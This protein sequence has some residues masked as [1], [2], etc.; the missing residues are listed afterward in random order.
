[1]TFTVSKLAEYMGHGLNLYI[2]GEA[3]T[4]KTQMLEASCNKL[5]LKMGYMSAPTLDPWTDLTGIPIAEKNKALKKKVLKFVRKQDFDDIEVLF[6]DELPRG[7]L[8]TLNALFEII[9]TKGEINGE[10][11]FPKLKCVVAAGNPMTD[12][13]QGQQELDGALLDRFDM[14]LESSTVADPGYFANVFGKEVG[15]ALTEWHKLH[16]HKAKG[17]LSPRRLEKI[18]HTWR[19]MPSESTIKA[20]VPPGGTFNTNDLH[21][22]LLNASQGDSTLVDASAPLIQKITFMSSDEIRSAQEEIIALLPTLDRSE[23]AQLTERVSAALQTGIRIDTIISKWAPVLE[24]F[25]AS[26]KTTL[27]A[28]KNPAQNSEFTRKCIE[29][30]LA[31]GK[32]LKGL[33]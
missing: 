19:K 10:M 23:M 16:D 5:G 13:Y 29:A 14:Y 6:I 12:D 15:K 20:M 18:G 27:L 8:K 24:Y 4:G 9:Q 26:D 2:Y 3:G 25:S 32:N 30:Q 22:R 21:K 7:E 33:A 17:Y 31:I 28:K 1:M 11:A